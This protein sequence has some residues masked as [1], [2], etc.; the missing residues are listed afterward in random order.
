MALGHRVEILVTEVAGHDSHRNRV[1]ARSLDESGH[2][3]AGAFFAA[4]GCKN[5]DRDILART[6]A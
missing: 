2:E 5:Q 6:P 4:S 3:G 1:F